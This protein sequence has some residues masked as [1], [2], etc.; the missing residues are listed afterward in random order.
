MLGDKKKIKLEIPVVIEK[1]EKGYHGYTPALKGVHV[2][3]ETKAETKKLM[4]D[5]LTAYI[6]SIIKH[7]DPIPVQ[8]ITEK[9]DMKN[10]VSMEKMFIYA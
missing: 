2:Y 6:E 1:D 4:R 3:G 9:E 10:K 7:G 5:A 8:I